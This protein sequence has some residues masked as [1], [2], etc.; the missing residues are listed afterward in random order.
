MWVIVTLLWL[1]W[2]AL[3]LWMGRQIGLH[4]SLNEGESAET[5]AKRAYAKGDISRDRFMEMMADLSTGA[6]A[7]SLH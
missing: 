2:A 4:R 6:S 3:A 1:P 5:I 7:G